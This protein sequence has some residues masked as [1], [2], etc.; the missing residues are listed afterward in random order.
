MNM[1]TMERLK[2]VEKYL[3]ILELP[4][5][6]VP[7]LTEYKKAYKA[8]LHLH[9]NNVKGGDSEKFKDV[10]EAARKVM[11]FITD[12]PELQPNLETEEFKDILRC[13]E[14]TNDVDYNTMNVVFHIEEE[15]R[16]D[17][18]KALEKRLGALKTVENGVQF[19]QESWT[20]PGTQAQ[21]FDSISVSIY[22]KNKKNL[23][24]VQLQGK[25]Y[26]AYMTFVIPQILR[27]IRHE[28]DKISAS[29]KDSSVL[30]VESGKNGDKDELVKSNKGTVNEENVQTLIEGFHRLET[31]MV[32]LC[33]NLTGR[34][35]TT[36]ATLKETS[37]V[38]DLKEEVGKLAQALEENR[39]EITKVDKKLD[40]ILNLQK[41]KNLNL[42]EADVTDISNKIADATIKN[43]KM[44]EIATAINGLKNDIGEIDKADVT[45]SRNILILTKLDEVTAASDAI[46]NDVSKLDDTFKDVAE[47][48]S[49]S[50]SVLNKMNKN[51]EA[52]VNSRVLTD[53]PLEASKATSAANKEK[54]DEVIA[55]TKKKTNRVDETKSTEVTVRNALVFSDSIAQRC[56]IKR[57]ENDLQCKVRVVPT[58]RIEKK[59]KCRD[60]E[61]YLEKLLEAELKA[62]KVDFVI[63]SVGANDITDMEYDSNS[64]AALNTA[65]CGHSKA[66]AY[67]AEVAVQKHNI[68]IFVVE[69]APRS[70]SENM[71]TLSGSAN[72]L[73]MSLITPVEK[74]HLITLP[75]L[76][77]HG[78]R[79]KKDCFQPDGIHLSEK[80]ANLMSTDIC[81]G[82]K[83][84]FTDLRKNNREQQTSKHHDGSN[85]R[86]GGSQTSQRGFGD[87]RGR[88]QHWIGQNGGGQQWNGQRGRG[89]QW[90]ENHNGHQYRGNNGGYRGPQAGWNHGNQQWNNGHGRDPMPDMVQEYIMRSFMDGP[91]MRGRY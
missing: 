45:K 87:W 71:S 28:G 11:E 59:E 46:G 69:R 22:N 67:L 7:N 21:S 39:S 5:E 56:D 70:D 29:K 60:P 68:D 64:Y 24:K 49:Q 19:K 88:G 15:K 53:V 33:D 36:V 12:N 72:G 2:K 27:E 14:K 89:Q 30:E 57:L 20:M 77:S 85:T 17:W 65:A 37:S 10:S 43:I 47:N 54:D 25:S 83:S 40:E 42:Q 6:K 84:V 74:V 41:S 79:M 80:G 76:S 61:L 34:V 91:N 18:M 38:E 66:L 8:K 35:D 32:S 86:G 62:S 81:A 4:I 63:I 44:D 73:Y 50:L 78:G 48:S 75:S 58:Y 90:N 31:Q 23:S 82:I 9:P 55:G 3:L 13:F 51:I 1:E 16:K 52:L 26:I